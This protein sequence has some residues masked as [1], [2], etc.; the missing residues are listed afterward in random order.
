VYPLSLDLNNTYYF[1]PGV[2]T[3]FSLTSVAFSLTAYSDALRMAYK[4]NYN[5]SWLGIST[6]TFWQSW[7]LLS[8]VIAMVV[9]SLVFQA[10]I[11][12]AMG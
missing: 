1:F 11:F 6:L 9:F 3:I 4:E 7:M 10:W 2:S 8:R 12:L 5:R